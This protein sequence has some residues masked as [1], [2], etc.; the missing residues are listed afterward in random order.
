M[1]LGRI[2]SDFPAGGLED[3]IGTAYSSAKF[4]HEE[5]APLTRVDDYTYILELYHGPTLAFKDF[6]LQLLPRLMSMSSA[7]ERAPGKK[8][9]LTATSGDTGKA[10]LESFADQQCAACV[11]FYPEHGVSEAQRL[12]MVT[13]KGANTFAVA[14]RGN[15]DDAQSGVKRLFGDS[16]FN[17]EVASLGWSLSSANSINFGRL[18]PQIAYYFSAYADLLRVERIKCGDPVN[19]AVPTGNFGNILACDYAR[20]MGLP[21]G[22]LVCASNANRVLAD[23]FE[24]GK[25]DARRAFHI[26][27]SPSMDILISSNLERFLFEVVSRDAERVADMMNRLK[28]DGLFMLSPHEIT[29]VKARLLADWA[30]NESASKTITDLWSGS[31][32]LIDTHTAV[33]LSVLNGLRE[34]GELVDTPTVLAS[35]ASPFKFG[36]DVAHAVLGGGF[37]AADDFQCCSALSEATGIP[38]PSSIAELPVKPVLHTTVC[39]PAGMGE[40]IVR[41]LG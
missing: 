24:T 8:L 35:T 25:Y 18:A 11:V 12:Q 3:A 30:D 34:R 6:A 40:T 41:L 21:V 23:F 33:G 29:C 4:S 36:R 20:R 19:F 28:T 1:V 5:V 39:D 9:I 16:A 2:F 38:V 14:V 37:Q 32:I 17:A 13:Q 10:A 27:S 26:T 22:K 31:H 15:F 7:I